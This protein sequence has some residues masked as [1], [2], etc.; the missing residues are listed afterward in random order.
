M[1]EYNLVPASTLIF[2][3]KE[4]KAAWRKVI[5]AAQKLERESFLAH[6]RKKP[7]G[8]SWEDCRHVRGSLFLPNMPVRKCMPIT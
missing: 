7:Y 4:R 1:S 8:N 6:M 2:G 3:V 5:E